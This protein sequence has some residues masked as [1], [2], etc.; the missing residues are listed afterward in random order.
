[1]FVTL[2]RR[3]TSRVLRWTLFLSG[4]FLVGMIV[5]SIF[6]QTII[7]GFGCDP[8]RARPTSTMS[9]RH[10]LLRHGLNWTTATLFPPDRPLVILSLSYHES[11]IQ[12]LIDLLS[13]LGVRFIQ[14]GID[15]YGCEFF[16][17]C[18]SSGHLVKDLVS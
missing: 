2:R 14:K 13:P 1:M 8:I 5:T 16:N 6:S 9:R 18:R 11:P 17:S 10:H 12:D 15:S 3:D 4:T 7:D